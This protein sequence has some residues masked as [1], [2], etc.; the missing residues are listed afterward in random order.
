MKFLILSFIGLFNGSVAAHGNVYNGSDF[1]ESA[2]SDKNAIDTTFIED[3]KPTNDTALSF[4]AH[5]TFSNVHETKDVTRQVKSYFRSA[6]ILAFEQ[7][8]VK[9]SRDIIDDVYMIDAKILNQTIIYA[10]KGELSESVHHRYLRRHKNYYRLYDYSIF[11]DFGCGNLCGD[12]SGFW[13]RRSLQLANEGVVPVPPSHKLTTL[14]ERKFC[15]ILRTSPY[16]MLKTATNCRIRF[17]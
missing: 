16:E 14:F 12:K 4:T 10:K 2:Y 5:V 8:K 3:T 1:V 7:S 9:F 11:F 17:E 6:L 13:D 15:K